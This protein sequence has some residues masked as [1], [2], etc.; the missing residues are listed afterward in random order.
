MPLKGNLQ[1]I[2]HNNQIIMSLDTYTLFVCELYVLGFMIIIMGFAWIG[3]QYDRV[4]GFTC[5]S[6]IFTLI[7]VF[8]SSLRSNGLHFLP[9]AVG[10]MLEM[11]AYGGLLNG[12]RRFCGKPIGTHWLLGALLCALLCC[13]PAFYYSLPK[14]VLVLCLACVGYTAALI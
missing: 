6:L 13:F 1:R 14:R 9:V 12:F 10:N 3:S 7:A 11:L 5:L 2:S 4:L 8:L